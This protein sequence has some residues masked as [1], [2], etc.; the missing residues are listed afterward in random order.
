MAQVKNILISGAGIAGPALG[1]W[2]NRHGFKVTIVE[3]ARELRTGGHAVD[4]R[5][6]SMEVLRRMGLL[7]AVQQAAT[8]MGDMDYIDEA[9]KT[10]VTL[11]ASFASGEVEIMRGDLVDILFQATRNDVDYVF[12]DAIEAL[13][14]DGE[15]VSVTFASGRTGRYDL[16]VG[17]DGQ[18]SVVR[19][20]AFG[21][22]SDFAHSLGLY[23]AV[24]KVPNFLGLDHCGKM[25]NAPGTIAAYYTARQNSE[26]RAMFYF[27]ADTLDLD[28]RDTAGQKATVAAQYRNQGW[29][30]PRLVDEMLETDEFYFDQLAQIQM[31]TWSA[32]RVVLLG[33]A[34][35]CATPLSGMGTGMAVTGAYMLAQELG[36][37]PDDHATAFARY[38]TRL[39]PF[40]AAAQKLAQMATG[41]YVPKTAFGI[42]VR[43]WLTKLVSLLPGDV[44]LKPALD[45][46]NS[47][48]LD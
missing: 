32:G 38:E 41:G 29:A 16:V 45:A 46:A 7:E 40:V 24:A 15:G 43:N 25:F 9:G 4:F 8:H 2:L 36:R 33:D 21:P 14:Q 30:V 44:M 27:H 47:V 10:L 18:H 6:V 48:S 23:V 20:L 31:P 39:R 5:G 22:E 35:F 37:T 17:A 12:G 28:Y 11:P 13:E 19:R 1:F 34:A 42:H 26:A 3:R